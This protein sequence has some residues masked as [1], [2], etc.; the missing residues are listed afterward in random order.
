LQSQGRKSITSASLI[1]PSD[2]EILFEERGD[3]RI[4]TLNRK[5]ALNAFNHNMAVRM[6]KKMKV[7]LTSASM[8]WIHIRFLICSEYGSFPAALFDP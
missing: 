6:G 8:L 7:M 1:S 2:A 5:S 4:I 3:K